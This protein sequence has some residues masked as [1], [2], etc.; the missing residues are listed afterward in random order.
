MP[1]MTIRAVLERATP[2]DLP[3]PSN[4][5]TGHR[6]YTLQVI[7]RFRFAAGDV[8]SGHVE[9]AQLQT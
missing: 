7:S 9:P 6:P 8:T 5:C 1:A 2:P 3:R 4:L